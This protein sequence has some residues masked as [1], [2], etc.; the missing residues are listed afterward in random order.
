MG[1]D[2][3]PGSGISW[4]RPPGACNRSPASW[5]NLPKEQLLSYRYQY[6]EA[7]GYIDVGQVKQYWPYMKDHSLYSEDGSDDFAAWVVMQGREFY[8]RVRTQPA[9]IQRF[10]DLQEAYEIGEGDPA[11]SWDD[12]VDKK[13][14]EGSQRADYIASPIYQMRFGGPLY[15]D[16]YS[17]YYDQGRQPRRDFNARE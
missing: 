4:S 13:E 8:E 2:Y 17:L 14:Y 9:L 1:L 3:L 16:L 5:S 10:L 11:Y 6:E 12:S 15:D 7:K